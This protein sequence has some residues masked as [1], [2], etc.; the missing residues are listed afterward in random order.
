MLQSKSSSTLADLAVAADTS[1][2]NAPTSRSAKRQVTRES[3]TQGRQVLAL[4]ASIA[5]TT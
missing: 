4:N 3:R 5:D 1:L 2:L